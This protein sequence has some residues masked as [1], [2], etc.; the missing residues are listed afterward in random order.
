LPAYVGYEYTF[1]DSNNNPIP[2]VPQYLQL[3]LDTQNS[4]QQTLPFDYDTQAAT[5]PIPGNLL[6][7]SVTPDLLSQW[8]KQSAL[9]VSVNS[10]NTTHLT[11]TWGGVGGQ[12]S[13]TA[14]IQSGSENVGA[15]LD[16]QTAA[17]VT[18]GP[19]DDQWGGSAG[20]QL[21]AD[22][23]YAWSFSNN[24]TFEC[25][26]DMDDVSPD[27]EQAGAY[28]SYTFSTYMLKQNPSYAT[29]LIALLTSNPTPDNTKLLNSI[30][31]N[32]Q[33]WRICY[34]VSASFQPYPPSQ[35]SEAAAVSMPKVLV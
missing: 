16:F 31:P 35:N 4:V 30:D 24:N 1:I 14:N 26:L 10:Q 8:D 19:D 32:S 3:Y 22:Y 11:T 12:N 28:S 7:Y 29:N 34:A 13:K 18:F 23:N 33:P 2:G 21:K 25:E 9:N 17:G 6:S 5:G 27:Q 20:I 15:Y